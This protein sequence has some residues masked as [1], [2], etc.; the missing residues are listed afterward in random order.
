MKSFLAAHAPS[1]RLRRQKGICFCAIPAL[2][3]AGNVKLS[4]FHNKTINRSDIYVNIE[5][6]AILKSFCRHE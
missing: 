3:R 4:Y 1:M 2:G 5:S 6:L